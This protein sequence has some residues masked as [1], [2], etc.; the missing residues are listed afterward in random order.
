M[1]TNY[2][3][4]KIGEIGDIPPFVV[5]AY[6]N[7]LQYR[8]YD[9]KRFNGINSRCVWMLLRQRIANFDDVSTLL[10]GQDKEYLILMTS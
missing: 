10:Y 4:G 7:R 1:V 6:Q 3:R 5:L 2:F 8:N 9:Y